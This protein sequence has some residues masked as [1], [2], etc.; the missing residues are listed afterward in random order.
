MFPEDFFGAPN[1]TK[2]ICKHIL[3]ENNQ[4]NITER[5]KTIGLEH[6]KLLNPGSPQTRNDNFNSI[7]EEDAEESVYSTKKISQQDHIKKNNFR[8]EE[9]ST[10]GSSKV[11]EDQFNATP[12]FNSIYTVNINKSNRNDIINL[13]RPLTPNLNVVRKLS[14]PINIKKQNIVICANKN[15]KNK[16]IMHYNNYNKKLYGKNKENISPVSANKQKNNHI[17][18]EGNIKNR[19]LSTSKIYNKKISSHCLNKSNPNVNEYYEK[20][21]NDLKNK[22]TIINHSKTKR[23]YSKE[24]S[25]PINNSKN[26]QVTQRNNSIAAT[27]KDLNKNIKRKQIKN[28][29]DTDNNYNKYGLKSFKSENK[30][31]VVHNKVNKEINCIFDN[32]SDNIAKDPE[33]HGRIEMLMK[34]IKDIQKV[35]NKKSQTHFRPFKKNSESGNK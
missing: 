20:N 29:N 17:I 34:D 31:K 9:L 24:V 25:Y 1:T 19:T 2:D 33:I 18:T 28:S 16:E 30:I 22:K 35:I 14:E 21:K 32:L 7:H 4:Q 6:P 15:K 26:K 27:R 10:R 11:N 13:T 3:N 5:K 23:L 12:H 8:F